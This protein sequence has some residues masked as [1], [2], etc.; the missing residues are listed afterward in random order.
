MHQE[1]RTSPVTNMMTPVTL[2]ARARLVPVHSVSRSASAD[3]SHSGTTM[4]TVVGNSSIDSSCRQS[5]EPFSRGG[6]GADIID[7]PGDATACDSLSAHL[8]PQLG[9]QHFDRFSQ[10]VGDAVP[11]VAGSSAADRPGHVSHVVETRRCN[12]IAV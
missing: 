6:P 5:G 10:V 2:P 9:P 7:G 8:L 1:N 12:E 4:T 11:E 3:R